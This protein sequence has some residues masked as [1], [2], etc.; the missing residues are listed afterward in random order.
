MFLYLQLKRNIG[1][2]QIIHEQQCHIYN[3]EEHSKIKNLKLTATQFKSIIPG[4]KTTLKEGIIQ[5]LNGKLVLYKPII[6]NHRYI[7]LIIVP[8]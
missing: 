2:D 4:Y 1:L 8:K 7:A 5:I 6:E 3:I